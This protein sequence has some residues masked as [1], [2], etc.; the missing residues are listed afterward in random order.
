M[1]LRNAIP[2]QAMDGTLWPTLLLSALC[3]QQPTAEEP[4][5]M[6][7]VFSESETTTTQ[8]VQLLPNHFPGVSCIFIVKE[9]FFNKEQLSLLKLAMALI[10]LLLIN[11]LIV[12]QMK[13][14]IK[15]YYTVMLMI[16]NILL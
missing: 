16:K 12:N 4:R 6:R 5:Q 2:A 9:F 10:G 7:R 14:T 3:F 13:R 1:G 11:L 15:T 8:T